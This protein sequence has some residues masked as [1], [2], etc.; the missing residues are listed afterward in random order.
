MYEAHFGLREK[1]FSLLPDP[2]FLY[3]SDKHRMALALLQYGLSS[4]AGFTAI[5]GGIGT[6]KTTLIRHLLNNMEQNVTVG[7]ISNTHRSFGDLLQWILLAFNLDYA[8]KGKV[9]LYQTFVEFM[10]REYANRRRTVLIVD[11]AQNMAIDALEELRMLSNVNADKDQVLQVI[12]VGQQQ[13][14]DTL[15][16]PELVQF[17]QRIAVDYHLT[18]LT[19]ADTQA[20]IQHRV[21][22][23]GGD[24]GLFTEAACAAVHQHSNGVPR[25]VNL[26]CDIALVYG[27]AEKRD[28]IDVDLIEDVARE[29]RAGGIFPAPE[30]ALD[31][32]SP[33]ASSDT[34]PA[35]PAK[36]KRRRP[37]SLRKNRL[38]VAIA[39]EAP[40]L[41][42]HLRELVEDQG[43]TVVDELPLDETT[44]SRIDADKIDIL[45][46]DLDDD[47]DDRIGELCDT[48]ARWNLPVLFNDAQVTAASLHGH[49]PQ[50]GEK[51]TS[52]LLSLLPK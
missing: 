10:I 29:K 14:R 16:R 30:Q 52:K 11:E 6:G 34:P 22:V 41:R 35:P 48:L 40:A 47:A 2:S 24:P 19:A 44:V 26:L 36:K 3:L 46:V 5:T 18:P 49:D 23:A 27:Y 25:L 43:L 28:Q 37:L 32:E 7:L 17:A 1:P 50:F 15:R 21:S 38:R 4:Q 13:L 8:G 51:L 33:H 31:A 20:Y 42:E 12:L 45:L 39:S 9:E